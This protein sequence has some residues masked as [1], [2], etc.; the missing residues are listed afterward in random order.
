MEENRH[1]FW[2]AFAWFVAVF[3]GSL[4]ALVPCQLFLSFLG[5]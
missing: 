5:M 3:F 2:T 4:V 1:R